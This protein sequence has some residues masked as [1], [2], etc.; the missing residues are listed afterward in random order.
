MFIGGDVIDNNVNNDTID[1]DGF[2]H[3][4]STENIIDDWVVD[5]DLAVAHTVEKGDVG[6]NVAAVD[7]VDNNDLAADDTI[8]GWVV[9][10]NSGDDD[11]G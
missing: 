9:C 8:D 2:V 10:N 6:G 7:T 11:T 3:R 4:I 1:D 5:D